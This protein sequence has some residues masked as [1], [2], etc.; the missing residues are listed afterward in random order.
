MVNINWDEFKIFKQHSHKEDNFTILLDFIKSYY[1]MNN[2]TD[3]YDT[4]VNDDTA[5]MM[6]DKRDIVDAEGLETYLFQLING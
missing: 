6:L 2:P 5:K 4:L 3:V 1:N